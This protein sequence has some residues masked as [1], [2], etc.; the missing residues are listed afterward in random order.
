MGLN[1]PVM[2]R[3]VLDTHPDELRAPLDFGISR[4]SAS[5][6]IRSTSIN[7]IVI[8][9]NHHHS[10]WSSRFTNMLSFLIVFLASGVLTLGKMICNMYSGH[11][12]NQLLPSHKKP[13][14]VPVSVFRSWMSRQT[15][16]RQRISTI[17][18][19]THTNSPRSTSPS[20]VT[21]VDS[22]SQQTEPQPCVDRREWP[23]MTITDWKLW[24]EMVSHCY[25]GS[26]LVFTLSTSCQ[27]RCSLILRTHCQPSDSA[28]PACRSSW[29]S[30]QLMNRQQDRWTLI[31]QL[32]SQQTL[33]QITHGDNRSCNT[34]SLFQGMLSGELRISSQLSPTTVAENDLS[35]SSSTDKGLF[36]SE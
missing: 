32:V 21:M 31:L 24:I 4:K 5:L 25:G 11:F 35:G 8:A 6:V 36:S 29:T 23:P 34:I 30:G 1:R 16:K 19:V 33:L 15:H 26:L 27:L 10:R 13:L 9:R 22:E 3:H 14:P 18:L 12:V 17:R 28:S 7:V 2:V 20:S